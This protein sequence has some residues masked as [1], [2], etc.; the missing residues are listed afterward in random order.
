MAKRWL[1][2]WLLVLV[3]GLAVYA[4]ARHR[5]KAGCDT[6]APVQAATPPPKLPDFNVEAPCGSDAGKTPVKK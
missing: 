5:A 6:P 2:I 3:A 4:Y 1:I